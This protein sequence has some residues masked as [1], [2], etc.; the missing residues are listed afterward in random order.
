MHLIITDPLSDFKGDTYIVMFGGR[1]NDQKADHKPK[2]Y[3]VE[4]VNG[5]LEFTTY[6]QKPVNPCNDLELK[7]YTKAE[8]ANCGN[9]TASIIDVGLYYNDIWAYKVCS[10]TTNPP[11]RPWDD[12]CNEYGWEL[13]HPGASEGGCR[14]ELGIEVC[15]V[16]SE[17]YNHASVMF[18]D[19]LLYVYGGFS[20]RCADYCD[21]MWFYDIYLKGWRVVYPSGKL[22]KLYT[23][24]FDGE[25]YVYSEDEVP[26]DNSTVKYAGP[27]KRWRHTMTISE[28]YIDPK[29]NIKKQ[30]FAMFGGFR[31]WHGYSIE[32]NQNNDWNQ[33]L[34]R[35]KGGYL[36]D[37]WIY[38]KNLD[39]ETIPGSKFKSSNGLWKIKKP[40]ERCYDDPGAAWNSRFDQSCTTTQPKARAAHGSVF[41]SLRNRVWIY[42]GYSTYFPYLSTDGA[43]SGPGVSSVGTGGFVP[44]PNFQYF[45]NDLWYYDLNTSLWTEVVYNT[46]EK[47]PEGRMDMIFLL[48]ENDSIFMHG[49][50]ADNFIFDDTWYYNITTNSWLQKTKFVH[51]L[52]PPD[53][54]DDFEYIK[55]NNCTKLLWPKHLNRDESY[56]FDILPY[57]QQD[58]YWPDPSNG[59]YYGIMKKNEVFSMEIIDKT[60]EYSSFPPVGTPEFP[61]AATGVMQYAKPF[62]YSFN[63]THNATLVETCTSVYG[64]PTRY[65]LIDGLN[66]RSNKSIFISQPR[67]QRP[68]WD[69]CR[70]RYDG[71]TDLT[72]DLQ[73]IQPLP[74]F[75]HRA[76]F[77]KKHE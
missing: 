12:A 3:N 33:Y 65:F 23:D 4:T 44:Y 77:I 36:D 16:P 28:P 75:G 48:L 52:Y 73:Y 34:T 19:G 47:T 51:P 10:T 29:D 63:T 61:Y 2:T 9:T 41:D 30:Q 43:G 69:G 18:V 62:F 26:V 27:S 20:Q 57:S 17:R 46:A 15:T 6:D 35:P 59:P 8:Q 5:S 1:D 25:K 70:D 58:Y 31:L 39:F 54:T 60:F 67:P 72:Q 53:C 24:V 64:E 38:T 22:T 71:R 37:L 40:Q 49:G 32:N 14:I 45:L 7:Y 66:G 50:F 76:V 55:K 21:D 56:P 42:G 74:R 68:G 11:E 13:W